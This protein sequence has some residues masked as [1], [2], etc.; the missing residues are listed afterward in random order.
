MFEFLFFEL[1]DNSSQSS[2]ITQRLKRGRE[3]DLST[4]LNKL[5]EEF[6][7]MF[8]SF[9]ASQQS[10]LQSINATIKEIQQSNNNIDSSIAI[11]TS[12][13]EE[14]KRKIQE[15]EIQ[16]KRDKEYITLLEEKVED[17]QR[18]N[19][20]R[21]IEFKNVPA[22]TNETKED[23]INMTLQLS[24][25]IDC[26]IEKSDI[27]DIYRVRSNNRNNDSNKNSRIIIELTSTMLKRDVLRM[28]KSFN[29]RNKSKLQAKHLGFTSNEDTP[30]FVTEH[31]T[32]KGARL[33][34]LA[35]DLTKSKNFKF[36]W[37]SFGRVFVR[38]DETSPIIVIKNES[39]VHHLL[40][41]VSQA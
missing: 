4:E 31:L 37:T 6:M 36:C 35:R 20:K 17:L 28:T 39:Q 41:Q 1:A 10:E 23:L 13:N 38:K 21:N 40:Q 26:K 34:F 19:L 18:D 22:L 5:K 29:I 8:S 33:F 16:A 30:I 14:Y 9:M 27:K 24:K 15:M 32:P 11:L 25:N 3:D 12:Q 7:A 2:F